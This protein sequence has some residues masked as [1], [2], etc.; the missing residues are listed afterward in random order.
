MD[1]SIL[2]KKLFSGTNSSKILN[3][4]FLPAN[5]PK[6]GLHGS[7]ISNQFPFISYCNMAGW[8]IA[9]LLHHTAA[10]GN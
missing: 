7:Q 8:V 3:H 10:H 1:T 9:G 6:Q 2:G 5:S 4:P